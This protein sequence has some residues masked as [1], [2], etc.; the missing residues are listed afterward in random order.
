MTED[1]QQARLRLLDA[2]ARHLA[3]TCFDRP[4]VLEAGAGTGKTS[5][6]VARILSWSMGPG[7][8]RASEALR[9]VSIKV[10]PELVAVRVLSRIV[11]I[12]WCGVR[13]SDGLVELDSE[14]M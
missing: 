9:S 4:I 14:Q 5:A 2:R 6:L 12:G 7:W 10:T 13:S 3:Q 8:Q 1:G 11:A